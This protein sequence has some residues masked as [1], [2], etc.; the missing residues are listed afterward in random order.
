MSFSNFS[1]ISYITSEFSINEINIIELLTG[2][3]ELA[4]YVAEDDLLKSY[5]IIKTVKKSNN[6]GSIT[7]IQY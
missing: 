5:E 1:I 7:T 3:P 4:I 2:M 6:V